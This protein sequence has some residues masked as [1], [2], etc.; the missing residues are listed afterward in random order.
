VIIGCSGAVLALLSAFLF[1]ISPVLIKLTIGEIPPLLMAGLLYFGSGISLFIFRFLR[2]EQLIQGVK[3]LSL[4][5]KWKLLGSILSGGIL[6]P[7][8]LVYGIRHTSA[9]E[10]AALLN[11]ETVATTLIAWFFFHEHIGPR[12]WIGK[13]FVL[14]GAFFISYEPQLP[15]V[16][17]K[18]ALFIVMACVFWGIDN[19][20]TRDIEDLPASVL[21]GIKGLFAGIFNIGLAVILGERIRVN[22][23]LAEIMGIGALSYGLSLVLF[24]Y[25]LRKIGASRAGIYFANGPFIG[26]VCAVILLREHPPAL[27]WMAG[28]VMFL[29]LQILYREHHEHE[30]THEVITH[31]HRHIHDEHHQHAHDGSEGPEPHEHL[32]TH[33]PLTHS[34]AHFPD[35]HHRHKH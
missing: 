16:F 7:I 8:F 32:H 30:H 9:F 3:I 23:A 33:A 20:L 25:A 19:N 24:V 34:H 22:P 4:P 35:I 13:F 5:Q 14:T 10:V 27:H 1:G 29:G 6:A 26:M 17:S 18:P 21:A 31:T 2:R 11:L 28:V 15:F 12:V